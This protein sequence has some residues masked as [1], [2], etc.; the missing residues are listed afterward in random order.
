MKGIVLLHDCSSFLIK[1]LSCTHRGFP[2]ST[3]LTV[4]CCLRHGNPCR[5]FCDVVNTGANVN[6]KPCG[7]SLNYQVKKGFVLSPKSSC[8]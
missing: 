8:I 3:M 2:Q 6:K 5:P 1:R 7:D 4:L